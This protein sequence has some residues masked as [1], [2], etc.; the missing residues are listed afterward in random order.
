MESIKDI[1]TLAKQREKRPM[2]ARVISWELSRTDQLQE[3]LARRQKRR[4]KKDGQKDKEEAE[5][6]E[7]LEDEKCSS[8]SGSEEAGEDGSPACSGLQAITGSTPAE[9]SSDDE[10]FLSAVEILDSE[11]EEGQEYE[12][13]KSEMSKDDLFEDE[14]TSG[15]GPIVSERRRRHSSRRKDKWQRKLNRFEFLAPYAHTDDLDLDMLGS[16]RDL[17][18][19]S[20]VEVQRAVP[21]LVGLCLK[22]SLHAPPTTA[23]P[24]V[25]TMLHHHRGNVSLRSMQLSWLHLMM[26]YYESHI[27]A[28]RNINCPGWIK[29]KYNADTKS[30]IYEHV[31]S[32]R[33]IWDVRGREFDDIFGLSGTE[34]LPFTQHTLTPDL[35]YRDT[36]QECVFTAL[37]GNVH[38]HVIHKTKHFII[39]L[40]FEENHILGKRIIYIVLNCTKLY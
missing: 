5:D 11:E 16:M 40:T 29:G 1:Q 17:V 26:E 13:E 23:P 32:K 18:V 15:D 19:M 35:S 38:M 30:Y 39:G 9:S 6:E 7:G 22:A 21:T 31:R 33:N 4:R 20:G 8:A 25:Q 10:E 24:L 12:K 2:Y 34:I 3:N 36:C 37:T 27:Q 14:T 28:T